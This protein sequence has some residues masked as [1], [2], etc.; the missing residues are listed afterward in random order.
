MKD[1]GSGKKDDRFLRESIRKRQEGI[2]RRG[3]VK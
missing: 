3:N 1:E 2:K